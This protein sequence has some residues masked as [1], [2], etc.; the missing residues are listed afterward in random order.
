MVK[1]RQLN[2]HFITALDE[3]FGGSSSKDPENC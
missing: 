2:K 3:Y 1:E